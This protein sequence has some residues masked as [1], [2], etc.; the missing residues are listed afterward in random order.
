MLIRDFTLEDINDEYLSWL[1]N[2]SHMQFST[3]RFIDH[4]RASSV[5]Y[6]QSFYD[7]PNF[8]LAIEDLGRIVGTATLYRDL[9]LNSFDLGLLIGDSYSGKGYGKRAVHEILRLQIF[10][11]LGINRVTAGTLQENLGMRAVLE[12]SGFEFVRKEIVKGE[13]MVLSQ[14]MYYEAI[15]Q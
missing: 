12:S 8:F 15:L 11:Q 10:N 1:N 5:K 9:N 3:Q 6:V 2:K 7:T 14:F 4:T 13:D